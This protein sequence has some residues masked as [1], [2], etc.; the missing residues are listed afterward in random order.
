[1]ICG[2]RLL[3]KYITIHHLHRS[4]LLVVEVIF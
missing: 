2:E 3:S 1:M 4:S